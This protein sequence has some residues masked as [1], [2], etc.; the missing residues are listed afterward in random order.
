MKNELLNLMNVGKATLKDFE[1]LGVNSISQLAKCSPD[2][3]YIELQIKTGC[4]HDPCVWD[5]FAAAIHEAKTG[6]KQ[7]WWEWTKVRKQR[8]S[9]GEFV[10]DILGK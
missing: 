4:K 9:R 6:E 1:L 8:Q 2:D 7:K 3:L 10:T 5:V